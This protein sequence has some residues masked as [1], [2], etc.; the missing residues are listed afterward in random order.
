MLILSQLNPNHKLTHAMK[1]INNHFNRISSLK[2]V[3]SIWST[4]FNILIKFIKENKK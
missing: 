4:P 3:K 2:F 1:W